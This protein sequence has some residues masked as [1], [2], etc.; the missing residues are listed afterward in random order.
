MAVNSIHDDGG[1]SVYGVDPSA[2]FLITTADQPRSERLP[3]WIEIVSKTFFGVDYL[4]TSAE[5]FFGEVATTRVGEVSFSLVRG[6]GFQYFRTPAWIR[7]SIEK[8][9]LIM[10]A[11]RGTSSVMQDGRQAQLGTGD[12][13]CLDASRPYSGSF[14]DHFENLVILFPRDIFVRRVGRTEPLTA[15]AVRANTYIGALV[16]NFLRQVVPAIGTVDSATARRLAELSLTLV[17]TTLGNLL[18]QQEL[19]RSSGRSSLLYRAKTVIEEN[20]DD[21]SLNPEKVA[22][23]LRISERYLHS[24]FHEENTTVCNWIWDRRLE[25]CRESLSDPLLASKNVTEIAFD[26]GFNDLSHFSRRF[27]ATFS[28]PPSEF[29]RSIRSEIQ[30]VCDPRK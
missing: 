25:K 11:L 28:M 18:S 10:L 20:L 24:L 14:A 5:S 6:R 15:R 2:T 27:K 4:P 29:R 12:L 3:F 30:K 21:D 1:G 23:I 13:A 22:R 9:L 16:S 7:R 17:I 19:Y 26:C 8:S